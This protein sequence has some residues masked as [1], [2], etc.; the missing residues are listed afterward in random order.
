MKEKRRLRVPILLKVI[1]LGI[2]T[3]FVASSI[4]IAVSYNNMISRVQS[5]LDQSANDALEYAN[6]YYTS[7]DISSMNIDAFKYVR[8]YVLDAYEHAD[9]IKEKEIS[10]FDSFSEYEKFVS[11]RLP[12][13]Y[14]D[15]MFMTLD[16][17]E[18]RQNY[19]T[20]NQILL[21]AS[22][23]SEQASYYAIKDPDDSNRFIMICD[24]RH[25]TSK[26]TGNFYHCPASHY[27]IKDGDAIIDIGHDYIK[28]YRLSKYM[29]RFIEIKANNDE[30][31]NEEVIGYIFI[32]YETSKIVDS[33]QPILF[34]EILILSASSLAVILIYA[35]LSYFLFVKNINK[36]N[37]AALDI[38]TQLE[39]NKP[40]EIVNTNVK[41]HDEMNT[42]S[43][44]FMAMENRIVD[45]VDIIKADAREKEK[46]NAEL[47]IASKIQLEALPNSSF[48]DDKISIRAFMKPAKEVG[49]DFYD[50]FY[51][52][53]DHIAII[54]SDVSGKGVPA[55]LF[56]MKSKELIK[57]KLKMDK[58]LSDVVKEVNDI[59]NINNNESLFVTSF[60]GVIDLKKEVIKYVNCGHE[61][62]YLMSNGEVIKMDGESNFVLGGAPDIDYIEE[63]HEYHKGD[64]IFMFT[65][66]L[67]ESI[68]D[69]EEE[70][71]YQ[72]IEDCLNKELGDSLENYI[73]N[74]NSELSNFV[75]DNEAFDDVTM[76]VVR[77]NEN[78]LSLSYDKKDYS[79]IENTVDKFT[80]T[81]FYVDE[82]RKSKAGIILD[83]LLNNLISYEKREDLVIKVNFE[84]KNGLLEIEIISNGSD[85]DPFKNSEDKYLESFS[86]DTKEGGFGVILVKELSKEYSYVYKDNQ[87]VIVIKL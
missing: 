69:N 64:I 26:F 35:V 49:G 60:I 73:N 11:S 30:T 82:E 22:F 29:T 5:D 15:G 67:N 61:K 66:G 46:I 37:K 34:N 33:Y 81:F 41:S 12:Y 25:S 62:P 6:N 45:Y 17:P 74:M 79:I 58:K 85:Y 13:M 42:L 53:D 72:R 80:N 50:Y 71:S 83:E 44:S 76:M 54:I 65:D 16:Y 77:L 78:K 23:Y 20:I 10:D 48:D 27:D 51:V 1:L 55:S 40:F 38:T 21:N 86:E 19:I 47:E 59:L 57:S 70:F 39:L 24:S 31:G 56:M 43:E 84:Y 75:G 8:D 63:Q 36:L 14:A 87:S 32:E 68:N 3:S 28:A 52:D 7:P 4:A 18:F 2:I 9:S